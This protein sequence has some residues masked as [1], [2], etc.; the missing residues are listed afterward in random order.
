MPKPHVMRATSHDRHY[1]TRG[2]NKACAQTHLQPSPCTASLRARVPML[3]Q[4]VCEVRSLLRR[5]WPSPGD[6]KPRLPPAAETKEISTTHMA[7][8][9][10]RAQ[11]RLHPACKPPC[12]PLTHMRATSSRCFLMSVACIVNKCRCPA[13]VKMSTTCSVGAS[14]KKTQ[15]DW[16]RQ[17]YPTV[18]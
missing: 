4:R 11:C 10:N 18:L 5:L 17:A 13:S 1:S 6:R 14:N 2:L 15:K 12:P 8:R 9:W 7:P 3:R 16:Y